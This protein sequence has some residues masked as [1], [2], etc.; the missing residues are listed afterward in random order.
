MFTDNNNYIKDIVL[1]TALAI[2][3]IGCM[4]VYKR[5]KESLE[6]L[7]KMTRHMAEL[8]KA[9]KSFKEVVENLEVCA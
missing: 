4:I 8:S 7:K 3:V 1:T 2:A 5:Y 9:E 6:D